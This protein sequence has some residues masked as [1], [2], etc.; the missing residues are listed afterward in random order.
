MRMEIRVRPDGLD[1]EVD[2]GATTIS[3]CTRAAALRQARDLARLAWLQ[4]QRCSSVKVL[5]A[6][7][8]VMDA[9]YGLEGLHS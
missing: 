8:W 5:R 3:H 4:D 1:W 2:L 7:G 6:E 9:F